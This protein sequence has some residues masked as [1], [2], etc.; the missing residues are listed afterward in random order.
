[1][2]FVSE[3][4]KYENGKSLV[5]LR[6]ATFLRTSVKN[7]FKVDDYVKFSS[8]KDIQITLWGRYKKN[9]VISQEDLKYLIPSPPL[10]LEVIS[11]V[12]A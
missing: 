8:S 7:P 3:V 5:T 2:I 9:D 6:G 10:S 4:L 12:N 1:M 11:H